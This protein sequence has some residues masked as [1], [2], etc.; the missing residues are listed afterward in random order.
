MEEVRKAKAQME[1][2]L[3]GDIKD[4]KKGFYKYTGDE[5]KTRENVGT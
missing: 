1:I 2:R 3:V 4:G 5:K